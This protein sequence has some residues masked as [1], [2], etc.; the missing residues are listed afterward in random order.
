MF[1]DRGLNDKWVLP[2]QVQRQDNGTWTLL[3][4][5]PLGRAWQAEII[6]FALEN[7]IIG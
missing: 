3:L 4:D 7:N 2:P 1:V 5:E 6:R